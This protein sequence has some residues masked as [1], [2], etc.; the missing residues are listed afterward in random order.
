M[1][2]TPLYQPDEAVVVDSDRA[3]L[4]AET[5]DLGIADHRTDVA[6]TAGAGAIRGLVRVAC[7]RELGKPSDCQRTNQHPTGRGS[8]ESTSHGAWGVGYC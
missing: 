2:S 6:G 3:G 1:I 4:L 8:K 7:R 5:R